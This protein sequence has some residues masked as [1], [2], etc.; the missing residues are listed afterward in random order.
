MSC[1]RCCLVVECKM[2]ERR[3]FRVAHTLLLGVWYYDWL[4]NYFKIEA[5]LTVLESKMDKRKVDSCF[6]DTKSMIAFTRKSIHSVAFP[7]IYLLIT[8]YLR[9][10]TIITGL[11]F[12]GV[13]KV[14]RSNLEAQF[15][16]KCICSVWKSEMWCV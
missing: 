12:S 7:Q 4:K 2:R 1:L 10:L 9:Y 8:V 11:W 6:L 15:G 14:I 16:F 13:V 3:I 5:G